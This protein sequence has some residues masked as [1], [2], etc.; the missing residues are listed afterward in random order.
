MSLDVQISKLQA[1]TFEAA[2]PV[3]VGVF[4]DIDGVF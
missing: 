1:L 3:T 2:P 4:E